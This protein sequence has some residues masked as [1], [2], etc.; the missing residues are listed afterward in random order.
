MK[1]TPEYGLPIL[2]GDDSKDDWV[3]YWDL[4]ATKTEEVI[5]THS[6]GGG[7]TAQPFA[8]VKLLPTDAPNN[9]NARAALEPVLVQAGYTVNSTGII[10]TRPGV[11]WCQ[12][13]ARMNRAPNVATRL[14]IGL[15][16]RATGT[17]NDS[18]PM[19]YW[20]EFPIPG[21]G[22]FALSTQ[23]P[24]VLAANAGVYLMVRN[25]ADTE[26]RCTGGGMMVTRLGD[27]P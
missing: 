1:Q 8:A 6:G 13:Y 9:W 20:G 25:S 15:T 23:G 18:D 17:P 11:Y 10:V 2:T 24:V 26:A 12:A 22:N 19:N 3:A 21:G 14:A 5:K 16:T 7:G 27:A 4:L